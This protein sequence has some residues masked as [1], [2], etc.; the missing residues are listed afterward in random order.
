M[1]TPCAIRFIASTSHLRASASL[2]HVSRS[3]TSGKTRFVCATLSAGYPFRVVRR[4]HSEI[5]AKLR[6]P[7]R[8]AEPCEHLTELWHH[9][10]VEDIRGEVRE[11]PCARAAV[12]T[13]DA[14]HV[15]DRQRITRKDGAHPVVLGRVLRARVS[16]GTHTSQLRVPQASARQTCQCPRSRCTA[17]ASRGRRTTRAS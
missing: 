13:V 1:Y 9:P 4:E 12:R 15:A 7:H 8:F 17:G 16:K 10:L 11:R 14:L 2:A 3:M 5:H 6:F